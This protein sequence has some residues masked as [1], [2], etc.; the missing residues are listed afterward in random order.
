MLPQQDRSYTATCACV[1]NHCWPAAFC[2]LLQE[3]ELLCFLADWVSHTPHDRQHSL[4]QLL[5]LLTLSALPRE[6]LSQHQLQACSGPPAAALAQQLYQAA[7]A[8]QASQP[9]QMQQHLQELQRWQ[10][11]QQHNRPQQQDQHQQLQAARRQ[12][13]QPMADAV[14][15]GQRLTGGNPGPLGAPGSTA[16]ARD[17]AGAGAGAATLQEDASFCW[18]SMRA[19]DVNNYNSTCS[20]GE[21]AAGTLVCNNHAAAPASSSSSSGCT[22]ALSLCDARSIGA[23]VAQAWPGRQRGYQPTSIMVAGTLLLQHAV[24]AAVIAGG[25]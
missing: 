1:T 19:V 24:M 17:V 23:V 4:P 12:A 16:C 10:Q 2:S 9:Q 6:Q 22:A 18:D 20:P 25:L 5:P 15:S 7:Q 3:S 13:G 14:V 21:G 8:C 11:P